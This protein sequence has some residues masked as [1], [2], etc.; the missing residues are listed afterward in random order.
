MP[1]RIVTDLVIPAKHGRAC[2]VK[3]G[4]ILGIHLI[5][6]Q[7]VGDC[8]F[9]NADDPREQFHVG[10]SWAYAVM[11]GTGTARAFTHFYSQPPR[12][13][14]MLTV[15]EDTVKRHFG[16]CAGRCSTKLLA[17]RDK[18]VG[19]EVRSCQE[20]LAEAL[21][22]FGI[23]GDAINDVFNVF[24]NAEFKADGG[25]AIKAPE[26]K[27]GDHID[28]P[29]EMNVVAAVSACPNETNPVNNFRAKPMGLTVFEDA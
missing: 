19:P 25:F 1:R 2:L 11:L 22:P 9:F 3:K 7:Q 23:A 20:N 27:A 18:R 13:N 4:Q 16:N 5:E 6:G 24:M 21:A 29:A 8:A 28:L 12:E 17:T 14:V 10:Q 26:T 15:V